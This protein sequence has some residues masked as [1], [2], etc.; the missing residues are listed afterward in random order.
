MTD[1][2]WLI[3][4]QSK[5]I[6]GPLS[7]Q[8]VVEFVQNGTLTKEDEI[9]SGNGYWFWVKEEDLLNKFL[10]GEEE[11]GF[12]PVAEAK[13]KVA[14]SVTKL[15]RTS[16]I[17]DKLSQE[18]TED[19]SDTP[20][21]PASE[22]DKKVEANLNEDGEEILLPDNDDLD[23]PEPIDYSDTA[24]ATPEPIAPAAPKVS[25][26]NTDTQDSMSLKEASS[27]LD[28]E[29]EE[30]IILP[31]SDDLDFPDIGSSDEGSNSKLSQI[32]QLVEEVELSHSNEEE[33]SLAAQAEEILKSEKKQPLPTA[34]DLDEEDKIEPM[35]AVEM[36]RPKKKKVASKKKSKGKKKRKNDYS[37]VYLAI[38]VLIVLLFFISKF[39]TKLVGKDL[40][41]DI[42]FKTPTSVVY[43]QE[44]R[45][46]DKKKRFF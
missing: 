2:N 38:A 42:Q 5:K 12:N 9:C 25:L 20:V 1:K 15:V 41:S 21:I 30:E 24:V 7:K 14:N 35:K 31:S 34:P 23:F 26:P 40:F 29:D 37:F 19:I 43:A 3:R 16:G 4:T 28:L 6:L 44:F 33:D 27:A 18:S 13:T 45:T 39:Y 11:Q 46:Q 36:P 22:E 8:K 17:V 32:D 10:Y